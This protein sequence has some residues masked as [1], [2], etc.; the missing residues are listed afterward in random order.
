MKGFIVQIVIIVIVFNIVSMVRESSMLSSWG[1]D[2]APNFELLDLQNNN[3]S[4]LKNKH[5]NGQHSEAKT[6][7]YFFAPWCSICRVSIGNLQ[8]LYAR[9]DAITIVAVAL[10][11]LD[12]SEVENFADK[13]QL[14]FPIVLGTEEVKQAY[15]VSAY[16]SYYVIDNNNNITHRSMGYSTELGLLLR[17]R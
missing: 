9:D 4:L 6:V 14:S 1:H 15:Q 8:N 10:D 17:S 12:K 13:L 7:L 5:V 16:P 3:Q 11:Y 2:K